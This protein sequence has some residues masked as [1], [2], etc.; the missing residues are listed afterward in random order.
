MQPVESTINCTLEGQ[1]TNQLLWFEIRIPLMGYRS[2]PSLSVIHRVLL[3]PVWQCVNFSFL[4]IRLVYHRRH[5]VL[6]LLYF[7]L[8]CF[9]I[10]F[11]DWSSIHDMGRT[12]DDKLRNMQL[13]IMLTIN[14]KLHPVQFVVSTINKRR[15]RF[16]YLWLCMINEWVPYS[17]IH[18]CV[19]VCT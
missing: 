17:W 15:S 14:L 19:Y 2:D 5:H 8:T 7:S 6:V 16:M 4:W 12:V 13:L 10:R 18:V 9:P 11:S 3:S 1:V